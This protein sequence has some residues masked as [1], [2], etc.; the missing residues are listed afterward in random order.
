MSFLRTFLSNHV[1]ANL[2]FALVLA[3]GL[4]AFLVMPISRDPEIN[5][6]WINIT[7]V[8]PGASSSEIEKRVTTPLEDAI[9]RTVKDLRFV[10]STSRE[11]V[12]SILVRFNQLD[13]KT[14]DK[15]VADL[16]REV[17]NTYNDQLP[18]EATDPEV[19]EITTSSGFPTATV[20]VV[21]SSFDDDFRRYVAALKKEMERLPGIDTARVMGVEDPELHIAFYPER[22]IGIGISPAAL[23]DTVSSYFRDIS[24]G[25]IE[26]ADAGKWV[27]RLEGTSGSLKDI[28][29]FPIVGANGTVRLG[30]I[31]EVYRS[32]L[33]PNSLVQ[34]EDNPAVMLSIIKQEKSN[35][36]ELIE[37]LNA[38]I[39]EENDSVNQ[40]GYQVILV[41]DQTVSTEL[42]IGLMQ[43]NALIGLALVVVVT[44]LFLGFSVAAITSIGI[45]FTLAGT[46]LLLNALDMSVSNPVLLG[47]VIALGMIVDD[48]VVVVEAIYYRLA[49][50]AEVM[51]SAIQALR[52]VSAPVLTS[53]L[54]TIAVF[55]PLMLLPGIL[56]EY[57]RVIPLV[58]CAALAISLF[59]AFW[60]LPAHAA[61]LRVSTGERSNIQA[62]RERYTRRIRLG[63][64]RFLVRAM[65]APKASLAGALGITVLAMGILFGTSW[66]ERDFFAADPYR[67]FY[68][69]V[70][71]PIGSTLTETLEVVEQIETKTYLVLDE[72]EVRASLTYAGKMFTQTEELFGDNIGQAFFSLNPP[73]MTKR[74]V[75]DIVSVVEQQVGDSLGKAKIS[76]FLAEDG[77]PVGQ[78]INV[79]VRGV[80]FEGIQAV[81]SAFQHFM[82]DHGGYK[83]INTDFQLGSPELTLS[84]DGDAISRSG[85]APSEV[86]RGLQSYVD[87][88]LVNQYQY[89][90][91]EV[92]VRVLPIRA[93]HDVDTLLQQTLVTPNGEAVAL[94]ELLDVEYG[95]GYQN[96]RRYN[97]QRAITVGADVVGEG[98]DAISGNALLYDYWLSIK[99][100]HPGITL[101]YAGQMDDIQESLDGL[102]LLF[103]MGLGLVYLILGTQFKSYFQPMMVLLAV[104][105][106]FS[107]VVFGLLITDNPISLYTM[108]GIVA[109]AG[110]SV[111]SAIVLISAANARIGA[112]MSNLHAV[113]YA[114]KRR[115]IPVL[116][117]SLTTVA[118]LFS[119]AAGFAGKSLVWGPV[120]TSIVSGLA[121]STALILIVIPLVCLLSMNLRDR[122]AAR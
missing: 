2:V 72:S 18:E 83:N 87:G 102:L 84:L 99:H 61:F 113:I 17:Q 90:G 39:D 112:G 79:K 54:T 63:Y 26:P 92:D 59:E 80:S 60:I 56:G 21:T 101:N 25:D 53:V 19:I 1:L 32:A 51:D 43:N 71:M 122:L 5:F 73:N 82:E 14:F 120:A 13:E 118:G 37:G 70:E 81:V 110:I 121:F 50:G 35:E 40:L 30:E 91:E 16:R 24:V 42:A 77:I 103:V 45:P 52:E 108:Y 105:L 88:I 98:M 66:I 6:N 8:L 47:I 94:N 22:L 49:R 36:L 58:V 65:R 4:I 114:A 9:S 89:M 85:I 7:T 97:F 93:Y 111:N 3:L 15:R 46:F 100:E 104:P 109:L 44:Y 95:N 116:I 117:T 115:V 69:N 55:L 23:A 67:M 119:L 31:A 57:M 62:K 28:E 27:I 34:M 41:D 29:A 107:G 12:S 11:G 48:A 38:F 10:S 75:R 78:A 106:A 86:T 64:T 33:E 74:S 96:I 20:A 68:V 76:V